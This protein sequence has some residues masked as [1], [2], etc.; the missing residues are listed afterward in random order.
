MVSIIGIPLGLAIGMT[1]GAWA[2][3][4]LRRHPI[5]NTKCADDPDSNDLVEDL[6]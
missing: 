2:T 4:P 1:V 5:F 6:T 3:A